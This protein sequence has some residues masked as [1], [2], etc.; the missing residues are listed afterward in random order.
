MWATMEMVKKTLMERILIPGLKN[1]CRLEKWNN[2]A[3]FL[4]KVKGDLHVLFCILKK[5]EEKK[6]N[7]S[8]P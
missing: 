1:V 8:V 4:G 3:K 2:I 5:K 7:N 6:Q